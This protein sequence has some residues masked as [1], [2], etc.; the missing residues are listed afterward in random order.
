MSS[1]K[2]GYTPSAGIPELREAVAAVYSKRHDIDYAAGDVLISCG[3]KHCLA[4]LVMA[5]TR[6]GDRVLIPRPYW[7]SYPEMIGLAGG[8][9]VLPDEEEGLSLTAAAVR[10]ALERGVRGVL[11]NSPN[12]PTGMVKPAEELQGIADAL[13]DHPDAWA[14]SDDIY[15]DLVYG[16][17]DGTEP[18]PVSLPSIAPDLADRVACVT[19][20]SKTFAM[21][22]WRIGYALSSNRQWIDSSAIIQAHTTSNPC[23]IAQW[24]ALAAVEG[25]ADAERRKMLEAFRARRELVCDLMEQ[26]LPRLRLHGRPE[27]AFYVFPEILA[28]PGESSP[29][30]SNL[31]CEKLLEEEAV[32]LIPGAAFGAEGYVRLSFAASEKDITIAVDRIARFMGGARPR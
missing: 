7:V 21:T 31:F 17:A 2:T 24:A 14:I 29:V 3:A 12:N 22:G 19:G 8:E 23:S 15:E 32:A 4:N 18:R 26:K 9:A 5:A 13:R 11:L 1:G 16:T 25:R 27:G 20:V 28:G 10:R 30:D 6:E